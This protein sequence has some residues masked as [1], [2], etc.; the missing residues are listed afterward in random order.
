MAEDLPD[1]LPLSAILE[2]LGRLD[3]D[4]TLSEL[5]DRFGARAFGALTLV[6]GVACAL[7]LPPGSST[8]L[9]APLVLL[10]PQIALGRTSPWLPE[11]LR[12]RKVS[13]ADLDAVGRKLLPWLRRVEQVSKPRLRQLFTPVGLQVMGVVCTMLSLVL[14]LPIPLGNLLPAAAVAVF[15]LAF[16]L[17]DGL[18][19]ILG[20]LLTLASTAVLVLAANIIFRVLRHVIQVATGA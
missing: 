12:R 10:T 1:D 11:W 17:R 7:P 18:L 20:Y 13:A 2:G 14:I 3:H 19:A 4:I 5:I 8:V 16:I 6:F 9:G 15:S